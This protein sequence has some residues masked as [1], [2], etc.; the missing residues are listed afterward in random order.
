MKTKRKAANKQFDM[1]GY[2]KSHSF[3]MKDPKLAD[4]A[5]DVWRKVPHAKV[6]GPYGENHSY[7]IWL[8]KDL[9]TAA[10]DPLTA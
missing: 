3:T 6:I 7:H 9:M 5:A 10:V 2:F 4:A 1:S 8:K